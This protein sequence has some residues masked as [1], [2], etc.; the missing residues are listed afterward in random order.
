M[1]KEALRNKA[2]SLRR[3]GLS[4][5]EILD[6]VRVGHGTISRWCSGIELTEKQKNRIRIKK[7]NTS[8]IKG[9]ISKSIENKKEDRFWA[10]RMANRISAGSD[11]LLISGIMLYWAEGYNSE[12]NH[13]AVFTNTSPEMI[14]IMMRFLREILAVDNGKIK[15]MVRIDER[16]DIDKAQDYWS[17]IAN[18]PLDR[19]QKPELLKLKEK[20]KSLER[21]P[22]GLCRVS[23]YDVTV[24]RKIDNLIR[25]MKVKM[26]PR[27]SVG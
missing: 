18:I 8:L 5:G 14:K 24:R 25:L 19:F 15:I 26:S 23:V 1:R 4:Y 17:R 11:A 7:R 3:K 20:S 2:V 6:V 9:L 12:K 22:N 13:S 16:G 21:Y 10:E 27:S